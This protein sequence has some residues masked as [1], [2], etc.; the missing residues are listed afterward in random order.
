MTTFG[1]D[2]SNYQAGISMARAHA[3]GIDF[4]IAKVSEGTTYRSPAWPQ[5]RDTARTAGLLLAGYHY[6][7]T[8]NPA[9]EAAACKAWL[10]DPSIPIM[11][12][13]EQNGGDWANF[14]AVLAAFRA[15]GLRVV[16]GYIP[17]WW[18]QQQGSPSLSGCGLALVS[19]RYP[20]TATGTPAAVFGNV[21]ATTWSPYGGLTPALLQFTDR[22]V[23]DGLQVDANAY[24]GDQAQLA[25]L[26]LQPA[27]PP[28]PTPRP[29]AL[30]EDE[31]VS[32]IP[33]VVNR[34]DG[35]FR[36]TVMA[37]AGSSSQIVD[38]AW[39][40]FGATFSGGAFFR[41]CALGADGLVMANGE[42]AIQ[43]DDNKRDVLELPSGVVMAT[44]EGHV[45]G[46]AT[47]PAASLV[48]LPKG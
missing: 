48:L 29:T 31:P 6:V 20:S 1:I 26:L 3:E 14:L 17:R 38:R 23:V 22:A 32:D 15:A 11:L 39:I 36:T 5:Q 46:P 13:W 2:I 33:L 45:G 35:T 44:V 43:L 8:G 16:L 4:V 37:E 25:S 7:R 19:S 42:K 40:T 9:G 28:S 27:S 12:D 34:A 41:V 21:T 24:Q 10:G 30:P 18:W 47:I